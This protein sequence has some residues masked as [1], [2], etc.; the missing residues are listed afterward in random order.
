M[1]EFVEQFL[2]E[3]RELAEQA[4]RDLLAL[5]RAPEDREIVDGAFRSIHTLKGGAGI[6][7]F[8]AM[9][10]TMH[11]AEDALA[12]VRGGE[13]GISAQMIGDCLACIDQVSRWLDE[14]ESTG[15]LPVAPDPAADLLVARLGYGAE[16]EETDAAARSADSRP[17]PQKSDLPPTARRVL[18]EQLLLLRIDEPSGHQGRMASAARVALNAL[19]SAGRDSDAAAVEQAHAA[20]LKGNDS[21]LLREA[22]ALAMGGKGPE[23]DPSAPHAQRADPAQVLRVDA[24]R[25]DA[26]V[27]LVG[28]LIVAKNAITH[29]AKLAHDDGHVLAAALKT[30]SLRLESLAKQMQDAVLGLRVLPLRTVFQRFLRVVRELALELD[31]P[32]QL[33]IEGEGTELDKTIAEVLFEPLLHVVRNAMGHGIEPATERAAAGKPAVGTIRLAARREGDRVVIDVVDDGRGIDAARVRAIAAERGIASSEI[34]AAMSDHEAVNLVFEPGFS[35]ASAVTGLSGRGVG[36]DAVRSAVGR[37][38]GSVAIENRP[39]EGC[40]VRFILPFSVMMTQVMTV[41]AGGQMFGIPIE[42]IA[43]T[44]RLPRDRISPIGSAAAFVLR[45]QTIPLVDLALLLGRPEEADGTGELVAVIASV[46]G[47]PGA[48]AVTRLGQRMDVML[49]PV[50]GLLAGMRGIAGTTVM[51]DGQILLVLDLQQL[52]G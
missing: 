47:Q 19:R 38:G 3:S 39:G 37:I 17:S 35:T 33:A 13:R 26:L 45:G 31:R 23:S 6:M 28:E 14:I 36:M 10:R 9:S 16:P 2:L 18:D 42:S 32:A 52:F 34:L 4:T 27:N 11:A 44:V 29:V 25:L 8:E 30:A 12:A 21:G 1:N 43:E 48:L 5:E 46:Y 24:R 41:E 22:I 50:D 51:G 49:K 15:A 40:T 7:D 20:I